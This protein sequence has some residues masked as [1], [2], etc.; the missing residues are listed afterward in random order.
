MSKD[1]FYLLCFK[2]KPCRGPHRKLTITSALYGTVQPNPDLSPMFN[3]CLA[4]HSAASRQLHRPRSGEH[5]PPTGDSPKAG[6]K[7]QPPIYTRGYS[8]N[9]Y[10]N[11]EIGS[12]R[13]RIDDNYTLRTQLQEQTFIS[14]GKI[15]RGRNKYVRV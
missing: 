6:Y 2:G 12:Q 1:S 13:K 10:T 9:H 8:R 7:S 15:M 14:V 5:N 3:K 11:I 4:H